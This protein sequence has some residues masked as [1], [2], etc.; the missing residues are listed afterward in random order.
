LPAGAERDAVD[1]ADGEPLDAEPLEQA[2]RSTSTAAAER[3]RRVVT[4][5]FTIGPRSRFP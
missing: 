4:T 5:P 3:P 2:T 1:G